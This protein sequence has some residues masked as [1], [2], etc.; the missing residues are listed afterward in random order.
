MASVPYRKKTMKIETVIRVSDRTAA[1]AE[2]RSK[3]CRRKWIVIVG[4][5]MIEQ[6]WSD[7]GRR[8]SVRNVN[9]HNSACRFVNTHCPSR[10]P[11]CLRADRDD[12]R[13]G[14]ADMSDCFPPVFELVAGRGVG[15]GHVSRRAAQ[16]QIQDPDI[17]SVRAL[18][19]YRPVV[20]LRRSSCARTIDELLEYSCT[21]VIFVSNDFYKLSFH[22]VIL[23]NIFN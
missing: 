11:G 16:T 19:P 12:S 21:F 22:L 20:A 23:Y 3:H 8:R 7:A 17:Q 13:T 2:R 9:R 4:I 14:T 6:W 10:T 15:G 18:P 1:R 5:A